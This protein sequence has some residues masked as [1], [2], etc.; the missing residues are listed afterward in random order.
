MSGYIIS[1]CT[2]LSGEVTVHTAKNAVLPLLACGLLTKEPL[3]VRNVP[4]LTDVK[5]MLALL[6]DCGCESEWDGSTV[7]IC[8]KEARLPASEEKMRALRASVLVMGPLMARIGKAS[9]SFPGGCAI[10][11]RPID[12]HRKGLCALGA[13]EAEENGKTYLKG[14]LRGGNVYLDLPSVGATENIIMAAAAADGITRIENA[15]KEPEIADLCRCLCE[16]GAKI[17]GA[18]TGTIRIEG[19]RALGSADYTPIP[20]RIEAATYACAVA[21]CGGRVLIRGARAEH[22]RAVIFKLCEMGVKM[23]ESEEG[24]F[25]SGRAR[26]PVEVRTLS[27]PGFPTDAQAIMM[28]VASG[29][30]GTS[31]FMETVFENRFM[32]VSELTRMGARIRVENR[33]AVVE[34][35]K[36][37]HGARVAGSDLR[38]GAALMLAGL[39]AEGETLLTDE[40]EHIPRGYQN[41]PEALNSIGASI[42]EAKGDEG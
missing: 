2:S 15:A 18:G 21:G 29:V 40:E 19:V 8:A 34:G 16:M 30:N 38:A 27:Y 6:A 36:R 13:E 26:K 37:L 32:H 11:Q 14:R 24:L 41:L 33:V 7:R 35:V 42:R 20:D 5:N 23:C 17:K 22:M 10:G 39:T 3:T 28:A 12:L 1:P 4:N 9:V 31:V 25:V